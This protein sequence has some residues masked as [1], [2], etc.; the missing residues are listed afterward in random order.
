MKQVIRHLRMPFKRYAGQGRSQTR[1]EPVQ[2]VTQP[3]WRTQALR[4]KFWAQTCNHESPATR[5]EYVIDD[6]SIPKFEG[7]STSS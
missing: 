7:S 1:Y 3:I 2:T 4:P 6:L 5:E